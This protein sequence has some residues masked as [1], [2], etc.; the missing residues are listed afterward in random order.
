M[1]AEHESRSDAGVAL[2]DAIENVGRT[3][4]GGIKEFGYAAALFFESVYWLVLGTRWR[5][6]V[7]LASVV[8]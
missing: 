5:Q 2:L 6:P 3:T 1:A 4:I 7:R 8:S